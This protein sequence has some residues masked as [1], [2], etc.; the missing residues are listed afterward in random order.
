M[1]RPLAAARGSVCALALALGAVGCG[2]TEPRAAGAPEAT[3]STSS[4]SGPSTGAGCAGDAAPTGSAPERVELTSGGVDRWYDRVVPGTYDGTPTP[5]VVDLHGY[6]SGAAGQAAMS[7]LA[8]TAEQEGF[9]LATPQGNGDLPYWNAVPHPELPDDVTF[10]ADVIDDVSATVCIDPARVY[11]DGFS[12]GA[13]LT[14][15]V[16]CELSDRVAAVAAVAGL[17]VPEGCAPSRPVPVLAIHG[18][19]D[20]YVGVDGPPNPALDDLQWNDDSRAAFDGLPFAPVTTAAAGWAALDGCDPEPTRAPAGPSV[21]LVAYDG[22]AGDAAV[23]LYLVDGGGHTWPGS[24]FSHASAA[25]LGPTT[26]AID[27]NDV[28]WTFFTEHPMP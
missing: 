9:V 24:A 11:V 6:L 2:S 25:I 19:A 1:A 14:S 16:A 7:D 27:A 12:N 18:T 13:F 4:S 21:E 5:L 22:C 28:I 23:A 26:D 15:L 10:V 8:A 17:L 20:R 3:P